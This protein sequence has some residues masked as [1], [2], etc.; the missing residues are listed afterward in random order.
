VLA[1]R[2]RVNTLVV[3]Q[4]LGVLAHGLRVDTL[5]VAQHLGGLAHG[6]RVDAVA[7]AQDLRVLA[8][9]VTDNV[10]DL[11]IGSDFALQGIIVF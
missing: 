5:V 3:A 2:L 9:V 4:H 1:H 11:V 10:F 8:D 7:A 6:L